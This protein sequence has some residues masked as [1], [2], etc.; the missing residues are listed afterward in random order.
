MRT[1]I[2]VWMDEW[3]WYHLIYTS[4]IKRGGRMRFAGCS[5]EHK[6]DRKGLGY[7][8]ENVIGEI[9]WDA[10][11]GNYTLSLQRLNVKNTLSAVSGD[12]ARISVKLNHNLW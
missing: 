3:H 9:K 4:F 10:R 12:A 5:W 11:K 8:I 2:E 7:E 1:E 6:L